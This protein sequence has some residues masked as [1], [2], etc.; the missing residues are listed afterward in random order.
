MELTHISLFKSMANLEIM[1][2]TGQQGS[3]MEDVLFC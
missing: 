1:D 3:E 2:K